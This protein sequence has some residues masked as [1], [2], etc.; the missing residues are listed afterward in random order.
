[1]TALVARHTN[2]PDTLENFLFNWFES[3]LIYFLNLYCLRDWQQ[4]LCV[5]W[6]L[7]QL[8]SELHI[9]TYSHSP[10]ILKG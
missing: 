5:V 7:E 3:Y 2:M 1:M 8:E 6:S 4:H 10:S 9:L